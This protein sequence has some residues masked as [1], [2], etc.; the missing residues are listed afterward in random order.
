VSGTHGS[1]Q[2]PT[3]AYEGRPASWGQPQAATAARRHGPRTLLRRCPQKWFPRS[4]GSRTTTVLCATLRGFA[5]ALAGADIGRVGDS[6]VGCRYVDL[7]SVGCFDPDGECPGRL[8]LPGGTPVPLVAR[9]ELVGD[10][11]GP[12]V[13]RRPVTEVAGRSR[14]NR[15]PIPVAGASGSQAP[16]KTWSPR[17]R[18]NVCS[19][20]NSYGREASKMSRPSLSTRSVPSGPLLKSQIGRSASTARWRFTKAVAFFNQWNM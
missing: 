7:G 10:L 6:L 11:G 4:A 12:G 15:S 1:G 3:A 9:L 20:S 13:D 16:K 17:G 2:I 18:S 14:R 19:S 8:D 5:H